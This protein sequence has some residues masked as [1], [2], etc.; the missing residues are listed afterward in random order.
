MDIRAKKLK[1]IEDILLVNDEN[2][3]DKVDALLTKS[4]KTSEGKSSIYDVVGIMDKST[5]DEMEKTIEA[6]CENV[7]DADWK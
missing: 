3:I 2:L 6:H 7:D 1:I 4:P 5:A